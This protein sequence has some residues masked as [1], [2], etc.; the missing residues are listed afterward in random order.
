MQRRNG[1]G[2]GKVN[3][4][5]LIGLRPGIRPVTHGAP[6]FQGLAE[7]RAY[8]EGLRRD[9]GIPGRADLDPR[10]L[11]NTLERV[12]IAERI[13]TGL[14]QIRIAGSVLNEVAGM[15]ARGLPLSCLFVPEGRAGLASVVDRVFNDPIAAEL[16]LQSDAATG[17]PALQGRLLLLPLLG[18]DGAR[19]LVLGCLGLQGQIGRHPRRFT[20]LRTVQERL[21]AQI[22]VSD[23]LPAPAE[24]PRCHL[25]L[26]HSAD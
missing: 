16:H 17:R 23:D 5:G 11:S 25:R 12:F 3:F 18:S 20:I 6:V 22:P 15:D 9:G 24:R 19:T 4:G 10:G 13:G 2:V 8:W 14:V 26:V 7:V 21:L 1:R